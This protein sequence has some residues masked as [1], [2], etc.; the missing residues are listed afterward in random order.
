MN[1]LLYITIYIYYNNNRRR[2]IVLG[3]IKENISCLL[4][5]HCKNGFVTLMP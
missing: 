5:V 3:I 1:N 2:L 4:Q